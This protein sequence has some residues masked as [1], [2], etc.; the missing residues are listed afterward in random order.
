MEKRA[1]T[2]CKRAASHALRRHISHAFSAINGGLKKLDF[3][4][5][6]LV[7]S[8]GL[9]AL[10]AV[11]NLEKAGLLRKDAKA[12]WPPMK[13]VLLLRAMRRVTRS[14]RHG[15][16]QAQALV[17]E[18]VDESRMDDLSYVYS[19]Y[20]PVSA[21]IVHQVPRLLQQKLIAPAP[22]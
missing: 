13:K 1:R 3:F 18:D 19:G 6:E 7:Q 15:A 5:R 12:W 17:K 16:A 10:L 11:S 22:P 4:K 8:Y 2:R 20:A 14:C 9:E 21:R